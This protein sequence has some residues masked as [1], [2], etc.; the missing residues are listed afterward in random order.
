MKQ[1]VTVVVDGEAIA[2]YT[3]LQSETIGSWHVEEDARRPYRKRREGKMRR[4]G[5]KGI[6]G[7]A[8]LPSRQGPSS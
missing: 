6:R 5:R 4:M 2:M 8:L 3:K 1:D 7:R